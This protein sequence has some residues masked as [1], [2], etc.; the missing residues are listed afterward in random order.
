MSEYRGILTKYWGYNQFRPLQEN[1][2]KSIASGKDTLGLMPTGGGKSITFQVFSL[3]V[4]GICLVIT[5]LIALMKDQVNNLKKRHI[6]AAAIYSGMSRDEINVTFTNVVNGSYKFLYLSPERLQTEFFRSRLHMLN[7][8]LIAVDEA[9]CISQWGYD[10]RPSYRNIAEI[11][12]LLPNVPVLAL[13]ATATPEVVDDIQVQ[14]KFVEKNVFSKS[15]ERKNLTYRIEYSE[16]KTKN[17]FKIITEHTGSGIIYAR[18]RKN[19]REIALMLKKYNIS[20][21]YYHAGLDAEIR[22]IRQ[23]EWQKGNTRIMVCTNAFGMGIDKPDVRF[24]IHL[25]LPD[26]PEE[27]FQEAGRAG[28]DEKDAI[29]VLLY[30]N[31][32]KTKALQRITRSFPD[33]EKIQQVY[34]NLADYFQIPLETGENESFEFEM[35]DFAKKYSV[36]VITIFNSLKLLQ[37]EGYLEYNDALYNPSR[38]F[39]VTN[40]DELY[41]F[42]IANKKLD[43]FIKLLLRN[44][45]GVFTEFVNISESSLAR[46]AGTTTESIVNYLIV[47]SKNGIIKYIP[48]KTKPAIVYLKERC[49]PKH[50]IIN[51]TE[52]KARQER[53]E[54]RLKAMLQYA[55][56]S[57]KCRSQQLLEYFGQTNASRCGL[58][59]I[60]RKRNELSLSK[61]EFDLIHNRLKELL[62]NKNMYLNDA[63][64]AIDNKENKIIKVI[65]WLFD[66]HKITYDKEQKLQ[67][68][69]NLNE[70]K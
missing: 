35:F 44:Y 9:H 11:R 47:L 63:I 43:P 66:N 46:K 42:Q 39:F 27:Y 24:V 2:I 56:S 55:E 40:R 4:D 10:F 57:T 17:L 31:T 13:T 25:D 64:A 45:T 12:S 53:F 30:N 3:S 38:I 20:A 67:W 70:T 58:C 15:F 59:D 8:N 50:L 5:P 41:K 28:R 49:A 34:Q 21:D 33:I 37:T 36:D 7:V 61:Y 68:K 65:Q 16:N 18:S 52:Y 1:I 6:K 19:T 26:A 62:L 14:L 48:R 69:S 22:T 29:A 54:K 32:D 51:K 60:C 23:N